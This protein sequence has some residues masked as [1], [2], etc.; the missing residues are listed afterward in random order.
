MIITFAHSKGGSRKSTTAWHIANGIRS[1][2]NDSNI[3]IVDTDQQLTLTCVNDIRINTADQNG[4][5]I[6][7][8]DGLLALSSIFEI[9]SDDIVIVDTGGFDSD[10]N[11]YAI[12]KADILVVPLMASIHDVLGFSMFNSILDE[13]KKDIKINVLLTMVHHRQKDF[14]DLQELIDQNPNAKL[15]VAKIPN[16]AI[17]YKSMAL[18]LSVFD[19]DDPISKQY[20]EVIDELIKDYTNSHSK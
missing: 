16:K 9:H 2:Q 5:E 1:K 11:R 12:E 4:F 8:P 20:S 7:N 10:I 17:N 13:I 3:I 19:L 15:L 6:Y 14:K 18:G